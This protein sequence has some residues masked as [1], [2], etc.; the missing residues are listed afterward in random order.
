MAKA[1]AELGDPIQHIT[2]WIA[3]EKA[4]AE[5]KMILD[6]LKADGH[7][8]KTQKAIKYDDLLKL[9]DD[10][11]VEE[12]KKPGPYPST[13]YGSATL[14]GKPFKVTPKKK[15]LD[16]NL[17]L[18]YKTWKQ[19]T[20]GGHV[21]ADWIHPDDYYA[22]EF[23]VKV[24]KRIE[25]V[26]TQKARGLIALEELAGEY[27][28][29][30]PYFVLVQDESQLASFCYA[31]SAPIPYPVFA[32]G[33]PRDACH[34]F[35][36]SVIIHEPTDLIDLF[37]KIRAV[38]PDG[39][40]LVMKPIDAYCSG[41]YTPGMLA[42]GPGNDAATAGRSA[43]TLRV[44]SAEIAP[45]S[46]LKL[47]RVTESPYF[48]VVCD[49]PAHIAPGQGHDTPSAEC[50]KLV[51]LR[52]GPEV[53]TASDYIPETMV[54]QH[55]IE[56]EGDL[57]EWREKCA[58]LP[59]GTVVYHPGGTPLS[60]YSVHCV[61]N[62]IPCVITHKPVVG[63]TIEPPKG[64]NAGAIVPEAVAHGIYA[65]T[66]LPISFEMALRTMLAGLHLYPLN[67]NRLGS[68]LVGIAAAQ[69]LRLG[70]AAC[71]G[72][73]RHRANPKGLQRRQIFHESWGNVFGGRKLMT[74]AGRAFLFGY[75]RGSYGGP[76]WGECA[77][78]FLSLWDAIVNLQK[79]PSDAE[80]A[81]AVVEAL[82]ETT[83]LVHNNGWLFN[84]FS[85]SNL[86]NQAARGE[87]KFYVESIPALYTA[88]AMAE[89]I[90]MPAGKFNPWR[91]VRKQDWKKQYLRALAKKKDT[92][93][94]R[95]Y[96]YLRRR[97]RQQMSDKTKSILTQLAQKHGI[98]LEPEAPK[99]VKP[100]PPIV[101]TPKVAPMVVDM[102]K[103][104]PWAVTKVKK[105]LS[106]KSWDIQACSYGDDT[107]VL[108]VQYRK[109]GTKHYK[110]ANI[111]M[112]N[113]S[114]EKWL[115]YKKNHATSRKSFAG[116]ETPYWE[117]VLGEIDKP[118]P[119]LCLPSYKGEDGKW[120]ESHELGSLETFGIEIA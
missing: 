29:A 70:F 47:A 93:T 35:V 108:H 95:H 15:V 54:V 79:H 104:E 114:W 27:F 80:C 120:V 25:T 62:K 102:P 64:S 60:H 119:L 44:P 83:N 23:Q 49:K 88:I 84:K 59:E 71:L 115:A 76:T 65:G 106:L 40:M 53:T 81:N 97:R 12:G 18:K 118:M 77:V 46:L 17:G 100:A 41:I 73:Y 56:A 36:D 38:D 98:P 55:V 7:Q 91:S 68:F 11:E 28:P 87:A 69:S 8:I 78:K 58:N 26:R 117:L 90:P 33:C 96:S 48:E 3:E 61:L 31:E 72:E 85:D 111:N 113:A 30:V 34:G 103:P 66:C 19:A 51:Q 105:A 107:H 6:Q 42:F 75:W 74:T 2:Q 21:N 116:T 101:I 37:D 32:R 4:L 63:Q 94:T 43:Y 24:S 39:E 112:G 109:Q 16:K 45:K 67:Q 9:L 14:L 13:I 92:I 22:E 10:F 99:E 57:L 86:M 20:G 50:V 89:Q 1:V 52:N 110:K 82:N 5:D